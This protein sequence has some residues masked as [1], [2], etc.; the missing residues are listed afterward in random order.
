MSRKKPHNQQ[1]FSCFYSVVVLAYCL[2]HAVKSPITRSY[3]WL[4]VFIDDGEKTVGLQSSNRGDSG[5]RSSLIYSEENRKSIMLN[6][7]SGKKTDE[8]VN[9]RASSLCGYLWKMK[10]TKQ[11]NILIPQW[12][13]RWF[14]IG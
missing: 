10:S 1:L 11:K 6:W 8:I 4:C 5:I 3:H 9:N 14:S 2:L 12:N 13:K 7:M